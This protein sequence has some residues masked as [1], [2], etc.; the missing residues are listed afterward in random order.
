MGAVPGHF[1][2]SFVCSKGHAAQ[3]VK[4]RVR[5]VVQLR[6][7][8]YTQ[9]PPK[10]GRSVPSDRLVR[11]LPGIPVERQHNSYEMKC[12]EPKCHRRYV[13]S[14]ERVLAAVSKAELTGATKIDVRTLDR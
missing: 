2:I 14:A 13:F 7:G 10:G 11:L 3:Q 1:D 12:Q 8:K 4:I 5:T 9:I 6:T